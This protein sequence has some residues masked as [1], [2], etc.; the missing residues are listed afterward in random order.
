MDRC[1]AVY[2]FT[3]GFKR[4]T[5]DLNEAVVVTAAASI[6]RRRPANLA[7]RNR[8]PFISF[9]H[10]PLGNHSVLYFAGKFRR[11]FRRSFRE[12]GKERS[13]TLPAVRRH[14]P[15]SS[16][17]YTRGCQTSMRNRPFWR[18]AAKRVSWKQMKILHLDQASVTAETP[19]NGGMRTG[20]DVDARA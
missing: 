5:Q 12:C 17:E 9:R 1:G 7:L 4:G 19:F 11:E 18:R 16:D 8:V 15:P 13:T 6:V 2:E 10:D 14:P 20:S 3:R